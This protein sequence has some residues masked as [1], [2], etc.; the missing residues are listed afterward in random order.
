MARAAYTDPHQRA[1]MLDALRRGASKAEAAQAIGAKLVTFL[2]W[3]DRD[4]VFAAEV[5]QAE[6]E[7]AAT[8]SVRP[9]TGAR[10]EK[11]GV[12]RWRKLREDAAKFAP[13]MLGFL[14][15]VDAKVSAVKGNPPMSPFFRHA[16]GEFYR[17]GYREFCMCG[18]RGTGKSTNQIKIAATELMFRDRD[19]PPMDPAWIWPFMSHNMAESAKRFEPFKRTLLAIGFAESELAT[20]NRED[21]R[22]KIKFADAKGQPV[23]INIFPNTKEA[24]IGG[25]LA[26]ATHDEE[27]H[28]QSGET[29]AK[30][31]LARAD[32]VLEFMAG[33]FRSDLSRVHVRISALSGVDGPMLDA[34]KGGST[35][36]RYV[37]TLGP[38]LA[39]ALDGFERAATYLDGKGDVEGAA[40][41]RSWASRLTEN[42]PWIPAWVGNPNHDPVDGLR[43]V[44]DLLPS[45]R[46]KVGVWLRENGSCTDPL[47]PETGDLFD[48]GRI[49]L[50]VLVRRF[51]GEGP[52]FP[53]IDTGAKRNPAALGIVERVN[54]QGRYQWRP[55]LLNVWRRQ[56]DAPPLDLRL[57][58]LPEMAALIHAHGCVRV[59]KSDGW[60]GDAVEL[61]G[62]EH[63]IETDYVSTSTAW[64]DIYD[65]IDTALRLNPIPIVLAGCNN[66]DVAVAQ[67]RA[68]RKGPGQ[69]VI[70]PNTGADHGELG[71]VLARALAH[72]GIARL[73]GASVEDD[74]CESDG[75]DRDDGC[76]GG[77]RHG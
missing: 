72:A 74:Q 43:L 9:S 3:V 6:G 49:N 35:E 53:A 14:L 1:K 58:V 68:L 31:K 66:V 16:F 69:S 65:P 44:L 60:A 76:S 39:L 33:A 73:A 7:A 37:P 30:V 48:V 45:W 62:N 55:V 63:G 25:N 51:P 23:E 64:R 54:H 47:R 11:T 57:V 4:P 56:K 18:G 67:L 13:G 61:V 19:I 41:V 50:A 77:D 32:D 21:G 20:V 46:D 28:W 26:G 10:D 22:A 12:D 75:S 38:F 2:G 71:Q 40:R 52:R 70:S 36:L 34:L 42:D 29:S 5:L 59:W 17:G 27:L 8:G 15:A 24:C